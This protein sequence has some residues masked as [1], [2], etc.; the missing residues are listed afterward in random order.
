MIH[1]QNFIG[2]VV[3]MFSLWHLNAEKKI[4]QQTEDK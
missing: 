1:I 3:G 4:N 2:S